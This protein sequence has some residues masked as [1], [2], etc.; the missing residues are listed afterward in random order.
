MRRV[1]PSKP[2]C[3]LFISRPFN[4]LVFRVS[5][6]RFAC[7]Y[8]ADVSAFAVFVSSTGG[9]AVVRFRQEVRRSQ[10]RAE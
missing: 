7:R 6:S 3:F 8:S 5:F 4:A 9:S 10:L 2:C 1:A